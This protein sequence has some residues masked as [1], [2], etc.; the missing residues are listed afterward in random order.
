MVVTILT[1]LLSVGLAYTRLHLDTDWLVLFSR[2]HPEIQDMYSWREN[3]PGSKDIGV[4]ISGGRLKERQDGAQALGE[5]IEREPEFLTSPL[6]HLPSELFL[7]SGLYYLSREA[8]EEIGDDVFALVQA[9]QNLGGSKEPTFDDLLQGLL[10]TS[11][12]KDL[13]LRLM[14]LGLERSK[15]SVPERSPSFIHEAQ[16]ENLEMRRYFR[17][18]GDGEE[19]VY[20]SLDDGQTLLVLVRAKVASTSLEA[21]APAVIEVRKILTQIRR[22]F[23]NLTFSL[24]G[25]PVLVYD[26]RHTIAKDSVRGLLCSLLLVLLL[27][28]YGFRE[29]TRPICALA[30]LVVGLSWTL[31]CVA[32]FIGHL[33]FITVTYVPILIGIGIDFGIHITFRYFENRTSNDG[34]TAIAQTMASAGRDTFFGAM[35]T[36]SVFAVLVMVGFRGVAELGM[37]AFFGVLLCQLSACT[38]LPA[39]LGILDRNG[40]RLPPGGRQ[41]LNNWNPVLQAWTPPLLALFAAIT[42]IGLAGITKVRFDIHLLN[43]QSQKLESVQTELQLVESGR[44]SVLTVLVP[45]D[46]LEESRRLEAELRSLPSVGQVIAVST[47]LPQDQEQKL[48]SVV[49]LV[50]SRPEMKTLLGFLEAQES[51]DPRTALAM[52]NELE[53]GN[54]ELLSEAAR[55]LRSRVEERGP[56]PVLD[57]FEELRR[58]NLTEARRMFP[59]LEMQE[60]GP[61]EVMDLPEELTSRLIGLDGRFV[62]RVFPRLDIWQSENLKRFLS[63]VRSVKAEITGE[64]VLI[65]LFER[66]VLKTH[67]DGIFYSV[68]ALMLTQLLVFRDLR[69]AMLAVAPSVVSLLCVLGLMGIFDW[70]FNP[71]NFVAVPLLLGIGSVFGLHSVLR[72]QE[73]GNERLLACSTGPAILLSAATSAAGFASIG[74]AEHQGIASLGFLVTL[75]LLLNT[76]LSLCLL[77]WLVQTFPQLMRTTKDGASP[78]SSSG[79]ATD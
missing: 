43:M 65:S 29:M 2:Q 34:P 5:A 60:T 7:R 38:F 54:Q 13:V 53:S 6:Y 15:P 68:L 28:K 9:R 75:G 73:L 56:G 62:I 10:A 52:L 64:P 47:F 1:T 24:T 14:Q 61:L 12:G 46:S 18:I 8:L 26:E 22:D 59:L 67:W 33:N 16:P 72:M 44:S 49:R 41:E 42:I 58:E 17:Q 69:W 21:T 50:E 66:L 35:A 71:A 19:K 30:T 63:E 70:S 45:V 78:K 23:P 25:E 51:V 4:I 20:L 31:G 39:L 48:D 11:D 3:L 74:L 57:V 36:C 37:I 55:E 77:P 79:N 32:L 76:A 40:Y 27:F